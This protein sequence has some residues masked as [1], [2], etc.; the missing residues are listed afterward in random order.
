MLNCAYVAGLVDFSI[1]AFWHRKANPPPHVELTGD[2]IVELADFSVVAYYWTDPQLLRPVIVKEE[3][4]EAD[5]KGPKRIDAN[6]FL[7]RCVSINI[8]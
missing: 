4:P 6:C 2:G 1:L 5:S 7:F 8:D 3:T